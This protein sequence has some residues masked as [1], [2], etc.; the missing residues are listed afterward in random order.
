MTV[1]GL[2]K[3]T[4]AASKAETVVPASLMCCPQ[5]AGIFAYIVDGLT[6]SRNGLDA[7]WPIS[8]RPI[9]DGSSL[10]LL[11]ASGQRP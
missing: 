8:K 1:Y 9:H 5:S 2:V 10:R 11:L 3:K 4:I 7:Y 6:S